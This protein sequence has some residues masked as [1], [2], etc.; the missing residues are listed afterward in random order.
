[1]AEHRLQ[2]APVRVRGEAAQS[3]DSQATASLARRLRVPVPVKDKAKK[4]AH[5]PE[6]IDLRRHR[7][8]V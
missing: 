6:S 4:N 1:V 7:L 2:S 8:P 3:E 5:S